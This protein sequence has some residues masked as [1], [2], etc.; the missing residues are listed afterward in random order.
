MLVDPIEWRNKDEV[1]YSKFRTQNKM[2]TALHCRK[3]VVRMLQ[4]LSRFSV[5]M[6][7]D[8]KEEHVCALSID[9]HFLVV[10]N[11]ISFAG[12]RLKHSNVQ[13]LLSI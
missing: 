11:V 7:Q 9:D 1:F 3:H 8:G 4:Q 5:S 6:V 10:I 13:D 2:H 12:L